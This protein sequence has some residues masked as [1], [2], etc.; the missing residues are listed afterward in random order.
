MP[1]P[2]F[3]EKTSTDDEAADVGESRDANGKLNIIPDN[4]AVEESF[5]VASV[6]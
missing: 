5:F 4:G 6:S 2:V 3:D 1:G